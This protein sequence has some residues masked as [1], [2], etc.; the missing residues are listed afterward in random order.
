MRLL[1]NGVIIEL[2]NSPTVTPRPN[3]TIADV[4]KT[5]EMIGSGGYGNVYSGTR[6]R[7]GLEVAIKIVQK[8]RVPNW[9]MYNNHNVP[10]EVYLLLQL[11]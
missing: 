1:N 2:R 3:V 6:I 10:M 4:Y 8:D 7:D 9:K 11:G 5:G